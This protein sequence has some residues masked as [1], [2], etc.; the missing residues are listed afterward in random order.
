MSEE[1]AAQQPGGTGGSNGIIHLSTLDQ[2]I[3]QIPQDML[4]TIKGELGYSDRDISN[5]SNADKRRIILTWRQRQPRQRQSEQVQ[6]NLQQDASGAQN[7]QLSNMMQNLNLTQI[8]T[9]SGESSQ[10]ATVGYQ[11]QQ[12]MT[13]QQ[14]QNSPTTMSA[15]MINGAVPFGAG[16]GGGP[17]RNPL[18][19][20]DQHQHQPSPDI[21]STSL[22]GMPPSGGG[23]SSDDMRLFDNAFMDIGSEFDP[24]TLFR[25]DGDI[26]FE[27]DFGQWF[28]PDDS[29]LGAGL[30]MH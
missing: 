18:P 3:M 8:Q 27:R 15:G 12:P 21:M 9:G 13:T 19:N 10:G 29:E 16:T 7:Q 22:L 17:P 20:G 30:D 1:N 14:Q 25:P 4:N 28:I 6:Q 26:N 23:L 11:G 5:L 2:E 24:S